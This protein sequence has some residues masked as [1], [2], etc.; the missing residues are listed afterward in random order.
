MQ[1]TCECGAVY[2]LTTELAGRTFQC[3]ECGRSITA[4]GQQ[5][6]AARTVRHTTAMYK[7]L[8]PCP[9]CGKDVSKSALHCPHCGRHKLGWIWFL[10]SW[11]ALIVLIAVVLSFALG[12]L[13][14]FGVV[15]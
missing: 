9:D 8:K 4:P 6:P 12:V 3:S 1:I 5:Q 11:L 13:Q 10:L 7:N 15:G 2:N 14:R